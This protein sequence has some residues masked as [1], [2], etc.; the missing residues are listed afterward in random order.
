MRC[1]LCKVWV[2]LAIA[3]F[4]A[5]VAMKLPA[6]PMRPFGN[7]TNEVA[8]PS[9]L[10]AASGKA[11]FATELESL[12]GMRPLI[13]P[14]AFYRTS[15]AAPAISDPPGCRAVCMGENAQDEQC[16]GLCRMLQQHICGTGCAEHCVNGTNATESLVCQSR[17][18]DVQSNVCQ[19]GVTLN[20]APQEFA[21]KAEPPAEQVN[22]RYGDSTMPLDKGT[23]LWQQALQKMQDALKMINEKRRT[24]NFTSGLLLNHTQLLTAWAEIEEDEAFKLCIETEIEDEL[25]F[26]TIDLVGNTITSI[27]P[28]P[29]VFG[30]LFAFSEME[31]MNSTFHYEANEYA[32]YPCNREAAHFIQTARKKLGHVRG[33]SD[34]LEG[35]RYRGGNQVLPRVF[36][37]RSEWPQ[38]ALPV[39]SQGTCGSCYSFATAALAGERICIAKEKQ[40]LVNTPQ[41]LQRKRHGGSLRGV[42]AGNLF[43]NASLSQSHNVVLSAQE[44]ISCGSGTRPELIK[45]YCTIGPG[46]EKHRRYSLGCHGG[47]AFDALFYTYVYGLPSNECIPYSSGGGEFTMDQAHMDLQASNVPVCKDLESKPCHAARAHY[48]LQR[49]EVIANGDVESIMRVIYES[50]PVYATLDIYQ[51]FMHYPANFPDEIYRRGVNQAYL[52]MHALI[53]DGWGTYGGVDFWEG[54]N[55]WG[56]GWGLQGYVKMRKGINDCGIEDGVHFGRATISEEADFG[57]ECAKVEQEGA[58]CTITNTCKAQVRSVR[59]THFGSESNCGSWAR[60]IPELLPGARFAFKF[61]DSHVCTVVEDTFVRDFDD[62]LYYVDKTS[63][64]PGYGCVLQN[65]YT[66]PGTRKR[67]CGDKYAETPNGA[68]MAH[69]PTMCEEGCKSLEGGSVYE[70]N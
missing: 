28:L 69:P 22:V 62:H 61:E 45:P 39:R 21:A 2:L 59:V 60:T 49:P 23:E 1:G 35:R 8:S 37:G 32:T 20:E 18:V 12:Q 70:T 31:K 7:P 15:K 42:S 40:A 57:S 66:G 14:A 30:T 64:Y 53:L 4:V 11:Y 44:L 29:V 48:R 54:R 19:D 51:D 67:W 9:A 43:G 10:E 65:T 50:G 41:L 34:S 5:S 24:L 38:C 33:K 26:I 58:T 68:L 3:R 13:P 36:S 55:S 63:Q 27:S 25:S 16:L 17:C 56:S 46:G 47:N 6:S 52:G